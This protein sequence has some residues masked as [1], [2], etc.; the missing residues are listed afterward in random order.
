MFPL[1]M[2]YLMTEAALIVMQCEQVDVVGDADDDTFSVLCVCVSLS[3]PTVWSSSWRRILRSLS[4]YIVFFIIY[5]YH[6]SHSKH[7]TSSAELVYTAE[8]CIVGA[9]NHTLEQQTVW[10]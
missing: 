4:R 7:K 5:F 3:W 9:R 10:H 2:H 8:K 6:S 1:Q